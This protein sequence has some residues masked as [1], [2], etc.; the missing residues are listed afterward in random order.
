MVAPEHART[1]MAAYTAADLSAA[2]GQP[3]DL[4]LSNMALSAIAEMKGGTLAK[5]S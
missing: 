4:P 2:T 1:V 3:V 5:A